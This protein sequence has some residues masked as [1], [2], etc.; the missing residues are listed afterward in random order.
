M[1]HSSE[2]AIIPRPPDEGAWTLRSAFRTVLA[3]VLA[4]IVIIQCS[5]NIALLQDNVLAYLF[6]TSSKFISSFTSI[7]QA[8]S[9][10]TSTD[11]SALDSPSLMSFLASSA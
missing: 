2:P 11:A 4:F 8:A 3:A 9:C 6:S 10:E 7:V 5:C 1:T